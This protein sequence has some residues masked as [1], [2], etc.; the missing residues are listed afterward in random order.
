M[1]ESGSET[2]SPSGPSGRTVRIHGAEWQWAHVQRQV[3]AS[4]ASQWAYE[5]WVPGPALLDRRRA[6]S[7]RYVG[8]PYDPAEIEL[9]EG[10]WDHDHCEICGWK[11]RETDDPDCGF[12]YVSP[13]RDWVCVECHRQFLA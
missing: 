9:V 1:A 10:G 12:G 7:C 6:R 2:G 3:E 8:Q 4:R 5:K 13:D 11:L